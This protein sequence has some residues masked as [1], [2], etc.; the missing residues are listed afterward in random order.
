MITIFNPFKFRNT[1]KVAF[2]FLLFCLF[3]NSIY[4]SENFGDAMKW[5]ENGSLDLDPK[6]HYMIGLKAEK[7]ELIEKMINVIKDEWEGRKAREETKYMSPRNGLLSTMGYKVGIE[8]YKE[9]VR[10]KVLKDVI[11]GPLPL[12]GNPDY[13]KE[14]G[15]DN[16]PKRIQKLS[17]CLIGFSSGKQHE[18]HYQAIKDW[19]DDLSWL[20]EYTSI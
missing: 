16:S 7:E 18:T 3:D 6:Y 17:N 2:Y 8:G 9:K 15:E 5:Y 20:I 13:M 1:K 4:A 11:S 12:V 19:K 14:W 10:R